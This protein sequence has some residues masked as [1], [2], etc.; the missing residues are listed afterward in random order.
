MRLDKLRWEGGDRDKSLASRT[1]K[2]EHRG[3][4]ASRRPPSRECRGV[5]SGRSLTESGN[6]MPDIIF[7]NREG[8]E[9]WRKRTMKCI[10]KASGF[11]CGKHWVQWRTTRIS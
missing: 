2:L 10:W 1:E 9:G 11:R 5:A 4:T 7:R 8:C 6:Y 3:A